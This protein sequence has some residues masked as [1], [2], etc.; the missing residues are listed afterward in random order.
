MQRYLKY[1][2]GSPDSFPAA[3]TSAFGY[4]TDDT[5]LTRFQTNKWAKFETWGYPVAYQSG[6]VADETDRI[7]YQVGVSSTQEAGTYTT[8]IILVAVPTY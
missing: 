3:G 7:G 2:N 5:G 1:A 6:K 4:T 8:T